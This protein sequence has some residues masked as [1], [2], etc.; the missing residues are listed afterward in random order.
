MERERSVRVV[1]E[2]VA[3]A[4][5]GA[6]TRRRRPAAQELVDTLVAATPFEAAAW[7]SRAMA[8]REDS[9]ATLR[10]FEAPVLVVVGDEDVVS[11]PAGASAMAGG[12]RDGSF[13]C[14]PTAGHLSPVEVAPAFDACVG[15]F[16]EARFGEAER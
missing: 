10:A 3:P 4:F 1:V 13:A 9:A 12:L 15:T 5:T 7:A 16:L 14:L 8:R 11:P 6:T 2:E